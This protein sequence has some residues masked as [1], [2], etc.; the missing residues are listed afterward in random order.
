MIEITIKNNDPGASKPRRKKRFVNDFLEQRT[1][2][3]PVGGVPILASVAS[4][5]PARA[6]MALPCASGTTPGVVNLWI[7]G[8]NTD[9]TGLVGKL[10]RIQSNR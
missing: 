4:L 10:L 3:A 6:D 5:N 7:F 9:V 8:I 2:G 1:P